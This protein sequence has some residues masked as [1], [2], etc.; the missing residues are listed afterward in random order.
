[1]YQRRGK[2]I[3]L[4][5]RPKRK[6]HRLPYQ[7]A[8]HVESTSKKSTCI[9]LSPIKHF[10]LVVIFY[11][12]YATYTTYATYAT[13][14]DR[15]H[16]GIIKAA[17]TT[18][19]AA[20]G[21]QQPRQYSH[22][23]KEEA[24]SSTNDHQDKK[25]VQNMIMVDEVLHQ[26]QQRSILLK[27]PWDP[28][29]AGRG[30]S[31]M[32]EFCKSDTVKTGCQDS[33]PLDL[34]IRNK[35]RRMEEEGKIVNLSKSCYSAL[36]PCR[37]K[38]LGR[39]SEECKQ[40]KIWV[41]SFKATE[42]SHLE[43][44]L[45]LV[46]QASSMNTNDDNHLDYWM[47]AGSMIGSLVH[48]SRIPW[49]DDVDIYVRAEHEDALLKNVQSLGLA[50]SNKS[51][52]GI[53]KRTVKIYDPTLPSI[54]HNNEH[55][56]PFIDLFPVD[57][58]DGLN[59]IETRSAEK[60]STPIE[61]IFPLKRR[62]FGRMSMPFPAKV[63]SIVENR[64][65]SNF[66]QMCRKGA[67]NHKKERFTGRDNNHSIK[68]AEI[69]LPPP[70]VSDQYDNNKIVLGGVEVLHMPWPKDFPSISVEHM[71]NDG[72]IRLSSVMYDD[73]NE[74]RRSY[75]D[76]LLDVDDSV[77]TYSFPKLSSDERKLAPFLS[78]ER[79][80]F[81]SNVAGRSAKEINLEVLPTL[82]R[83]VIS[84]NRGSPP[85]VSGEMSG[86]NRTLRVGEWN[87]ERG[88]NWDVFSQ[89][90]SNADIIILNEMDWGMARSGNL[91]TTKEMAASLKMNYA[92]GVEFLE[93][94]NGNA[95][96]INATKGKSNLI[97]YH[98][99]AV[100]TK[101]PIIKS[102]IV[103]LHPLYDLLYQEKT[104]GQ[105][106]G[107]RRLGG[108]MALFTLIQTN[109]GNILAISMHAHSGSKKKLL[110]GDAELICNEIQK[111]NSS[112]TNVILGGDVA[113]PIPQTLVSD[114]GFFALEKTNSQKRGGAR[115]LEPTWRVGK[116]SLLISWCWLSSSFVYYASSCLLRKCVLLNYQMRM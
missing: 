92:Y 15:F 20:I 42:T 69:I 17:P 51:F 113:S 3:L 87:A 40:S 83:V 39:R 8:V 109:I 18:S 50:V 6:A 53:K 54:S 31:I 5:P 98:G 57:C 66:K 13:L 58:S 74:V 61:S 45:S 85:F 67:Y 2:S 110:K 103:R 100:L 52:G 4:P 34:C 63:R 19:D 108:R 29:A 12:T 23:Q 46:D 112:T 27:A 7:S 107:E 32:H 111:Y 41:N 93:L 21:D 24:S 26:P 105:A 35:V 77:V 102:E 36:S 70:F 106:M 97:G 79:L 86:R 22:Y 62:P 101:W 64:Y 80:S 71:I 78:E 91:D 99:N 56:Y 81:L 25:L 89:F 48:H 88:H 43:K 114:C 104:A 115:G 84:N 90:Y 16:L 73:H 68:C 65:G 14:G 9:K 95:K 75:A 94:T 30:H 37:S 1:M 59:C 60:Y 33:L 47:T 96:E 49:D 116:C 55:S 44:L 11:A 28:T 10:A 38:L 76:G 82:D 72:G